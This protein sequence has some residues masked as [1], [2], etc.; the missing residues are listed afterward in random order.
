VDG[1][2]AGESGESEVASSR[3]SV[4][5]PV[6]TLGD[7]WRAVEA[8]EREGPREGSPSDRAFSGGWGPGTDDP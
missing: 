4:E 5:P 7:I 6:R 2:V 1:G 8:R 3:R